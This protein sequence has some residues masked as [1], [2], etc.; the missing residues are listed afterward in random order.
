MC[1]CKKLNHRFAQAL[2]PSS[3]RLNTIAV[4][5]LNKCST[6]YRPHAFCTPNFRRHFRDCTDVVQR[7]KLAN[8]DDFEI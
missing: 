1:R 4:Y 3:W 5:F 2:S 8:Y 6:S 7:M